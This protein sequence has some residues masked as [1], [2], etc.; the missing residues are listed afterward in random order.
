MN[1]AIDMV[2]GSAQARVATKETTRLEKELARTQEFLDVMRELEAQQETKAQREQRLKDEK[3]AR[4]AKRDRDKR[5]ADLRA[6]IAR[7]RSRL[8]SGGALDTG[9]AAQLS[10][11]EAELFHILM[12]F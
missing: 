4:D 2:A 12:S 6:R 9:V 3:V 8:Y 1:D 10:A 11:A 7:L 5:I